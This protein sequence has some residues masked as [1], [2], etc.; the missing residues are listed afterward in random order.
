MPEC[1]C[2]IEIYCPM[3]ERMKQVEDEAFT[4]YINNERSVPYF[5]PYME[6]A[7]IRR[8][9]RDKALKRG[10]YEHAKGYKGPTRG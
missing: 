3:A 5:W 6:A 2:T 9:H 1:G 10:A 7:D 4:R 8:D